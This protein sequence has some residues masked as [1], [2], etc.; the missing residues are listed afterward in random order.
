M[1]K[2][3]D[4]T[5]FSDGAYVSGDADGKF[6]RQKT[7]FHNFVTADGSSGY[8]A[9]AGRYHLYV[10]LACPWAHRT[11]IM[12]ALKGLEDVISVSV[13]NLFTGPDGWTFDEGPAVT[14][15]P[16]YGATH[17]KDIYKA[18]QDDY[19]GRVTVPVLFDTKTRTIVN[20]E[21][22]EIIRM[23][24]TE[25]GAFAKPTAWTDHDFY[26]AALRP[27]I[28]PVNERVYHTV[29]NGVYKAG[30]AGTQAAYEDAFDALFDT[31]DWLE[32]RL[33]RKRYLAGD[34]LTEADIRL[35]T[36]LIRFDKVYHGHF[37]C[38]KRRLVDYPNLWAYTRELYQ[39]EGFAD[40]VNFEHIV[41]H[42][43]QSHTSVNPRGIYAI[44]PELDLD[45][46]HG[47]ERVS[48]TMRH[49]STTVSNASHRALHL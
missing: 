23:F 29:N 39:I 13:V 17:L 22:S 1:G 38:N 34:T 16:V 27:E 8:P 36:T 46:P 47:R 24:D 18:V 28:D 19:T 20:N 43:Y 32:E 37:K 11:L 10:S 5:W 3:I 14:P 21:S 15:D 2:F 26:P 48:D 4:G 31:L 12:R 9:E 41:K 7:S 42:Y 30:F 25:F 40:A 6:R 33:S 35:W 45:A 49:V 44:G